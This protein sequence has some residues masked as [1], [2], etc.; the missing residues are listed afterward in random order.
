MEE[1]DSGSE[2]AAPSTWKGTLV[3]GTP[4]PEYSSEEGAAAVLESVENPEAYEFETHANE[5]VS[6]E[7]LADL[8]PESTEDGE[9]ELLDATSQEPLAPLAQEAQVDELQPDVSDRHSSETQDSQADS[10]RTTAP[11]RIRPVRFEIVLPELSPEERAHYRVVHSDRVDFV[12]EE[13]AEQPYDPY[14]R[15]EYTDGRQHLVSEL[16]LAAHHG[17][18]TALRRWHAGI[19]PE[20]IFKM[21]RRTAHKRSWEDGTEDSASTGSLDDMMNVDDDDEERMRTL[22]KR[23]RTSA[24]ASTSRTIPFSS[25]E[26]EPTAPAPPARQLR[27]RQPRQLKLTKMA[28]ANGNSFGDDDDELALAN[29]LHKSDGEDDDFQH[30]TSDVVPRTGRGR[31]N[32]KRLKPSRSNYAARSSR[33]SSIEFEDD[34]RRSGRSTRNTKNMT[35]PTAMDDDLSSAEESKTTAAPKVISIKEVFKPLPS[36]SDF[37][38]YHVSVCDVCNQGSV[39][40]K[41]QMIG[42][43]G[44]SLSFHKG[45]INSRAQRD[46]MATKVGDDSFVLQCKWCIGIYRKKDANAPHHAMCQ[47]CKEDGKACKPFSMKKTAREE[48][49]LRQENGGVDPVT[50]VEP[51]LVNNSGIVLFRCTACKRGWHFEH[52]PSSRTESD[53][54]GTR[55]QR[56]ADY[57]IDWKCEDC[58]LRNDKVHV[59]VAWRPTGKKEGAIEDG[60]ATPDFSSLPEDGKEYLVKWANQSYFH[61]T[62]MPG[63]W[64]HGTT[65][66]AMRTTFAKRDAERSLLRMNKQ[67]AI[68]EEYLLADVILYAKSDNQ[69]SSKAAEMARI[70]KVSKIFVKFQG[71]GYDDAVWD[72]PPPPES[73]RPYEA[74]KEAYEEYLCGKYFAPGVGPKMLERVRAW[75]RKE[76]VELKEQPRGIKRGKLMKYQ[77]E[78]VNWMLSSYHTGRNVILADEM[79]LGKTVQVPTVLAI[80]GGGAQLDMSQ[81]ASRD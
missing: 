58:S 17:G 36:D 12:Y 81:L 64:V 18:K 41:G 44:C 40:S 47:S 26:D 21:S 52:L 28:F 4:E 3:F 9:D 62:W 69:A 25:D 70:H 11:E 71:L 75:K 39:S 8:L 54:A 63:A 57:S 16:D 34:R 65:A 42:C 6:N 74:F 13:I 61:C 2:P 53:V 55:E 66:G 10:L 24:R 37:S 72:S 20:D 32:V 80:Y 60:E 45:C 23:R 31:K 43:Q 29:S 67:D 68:P 5:D 59:L 27:D 19:T 48:E 7:A 14:Y 56:L 15:I 77:E 76:F 30:I 49:K 73:G 78:G 33:D 50:K 79:G 46:H 1:T 35:D 22:H 38:E 51:Y